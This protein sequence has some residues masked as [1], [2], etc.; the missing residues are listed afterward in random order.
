MS[1][2]NP[3]GL[4]PTLQLAGSRELKELK[5]GQRVGGYVGYPTERLSLAS[6]GIGSP[7]VF[8]DSDGVIMLVTDYFLA[9]NVA[10]ERLLIN[11]SFP[12]AGAAS[13]SPILNRWGEVVAI[14]STYGE[15][16]HPV[17]I[18]FAQR[19]DLLG[20]LLAGTADRHMPAHLKQWEDGLA[21]HTHGRVNASVRS[22]PTV[23]PRDSRATSRSIL[24]RGEPR[25]CQFRLRVDRSNRH[26]GQRLGDRMVW[27]GRRRDLS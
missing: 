26:E 4:G 9:D 6:A 23:G 11:H 10:G 21:R 27:R 19:S 12:V 2:A 3:K 5:P 24:P 20:E 22:F 14:I 1:V 7:V 8:P 13:G 16:P 17:V 18:R 15:E 25:K